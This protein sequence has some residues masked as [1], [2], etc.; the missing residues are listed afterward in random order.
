MQTLRRIATFLFFCNR[1]FQNS[2]YKE[3]HYSENR[4][5][6]R[7]HGRRKQLPSDGI[8][9]LRGRRGRRTTRLSLKNRKCLTTKMPRFDLKTKKIC[10]P[11]T[12]WKKTFPNASNWECHRSSTRKDSWKCVRPYFSNKL[13]SKEAWRSPTKVLKTS[14]EE[15]TNT[16]NLFGIFAGNPT[17]FIS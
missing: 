8:Q 6:E 5:V 4:P 11:T 17:I 7:R 12:I 13:P 9:P 3:N 14:T 1:I 16:L 15:K 2:C 10:H